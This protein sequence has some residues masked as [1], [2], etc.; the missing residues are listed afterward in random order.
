MQEADYLVSQPLDEM[1]E[2]IKHAMCVLPLPL[3]HA[4][5]K[6]KS[7]TALPADLKIAHVQDSAHGFTTW[8]LQVTAR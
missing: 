6:S 4:M 8:P 2:V 3:L 7:C 1:I 5:Q